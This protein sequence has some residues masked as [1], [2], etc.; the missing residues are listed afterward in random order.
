MNFVANGELEHR[1]EIVKYRKKEH[2]YDYNDIPGYL[3]TMSWIS[4]LLSTRTMNS[5]KNLK[6]KHKWISG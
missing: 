3:C 4:H 2:Y 5:E 1:I 6:E